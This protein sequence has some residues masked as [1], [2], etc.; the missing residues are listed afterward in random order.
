VNNH[1]FAKLKKCFVFNRMFLTLRF[2]Q[3]F[4]EVYIVY[5]AKRNQ[6]L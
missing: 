2:A 6:K 3:N 4:R 5:T 1:I